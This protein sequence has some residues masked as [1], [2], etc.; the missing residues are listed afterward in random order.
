MRIVISVGVLFLAV[1]FGL[2]YVSADDTEPLTAISLPSDEKYQKVLQHEALRE[3]ILRK[4]LTPEEEK[5]KAEGYE[6]NQ[7]NQFISD[8]LPLSRYFYD[9]RDVSCLK[10][11]YFPV[12]NMPTVSVVIIFHNEARST[13]LRTVQS[14]L[15]RTPRRLLHEIILVDDGS[16]HEFLKA[17]LDADLANFPKTQLIRLTERSGLIR[18]KVHGA[19]AATGDVLMFMDSHCE[20]VD[21]WLEPLLDRIMRDRRTIAMPVIDAIEEGTWEFRTSILQRGVF[22]WSLQFYWLD[23]TEA[24]AALRRSPAEPIVT[25][26]MAGGIFA[27]DRKYFFEIGAYD[28]DMDTWGGE[29]IE[30]SFRVWMCGGRLEILP[31]SRVGH[32]FRAKSPYSFKKDP[33]ETIAHNLNRAARVWMDDRAEIYLNFTNNSRFGESDISERVQLR[34]DLKCH[35]FQWYLDNVFP[36]AFVPVPE[37]SQTLGFLRN[38]TFNMC[39]VQAAHGDDARFANTV[40]AAL[41]RCFEDTDESFDHTWWYLTKTPKAGQLRNED[42]NGA[43]CA[44]P[45]EFALGASISLVH[46]HHHADA[47]DLTWEHTN[48]GELVHVATGLCLTQSGEGDLVV[49]TC[50]AEDQGQVWEFFDEIPDEEEESETGH[51]GEGEASQGG[52]EV[53]ASE[54]EADA[55]PDGESEGEAYPEGESESEDGVVHLDPSSFDIGELPEGAVLESVTV[56]DAQP[57]MQ[58]DIIITREPVVDEPAV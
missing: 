47:D 11:K 34:K 2:F 55:H 30:M 36:D 22:S 5:E 33:T 56:Q 49:D 18:A 37:H 13:L 8:R 42:E 6:R 32:V 16:T 41:Q 28:M 4:K 40:P 7:F 29:N 20:C 46:C 23:I 9:T 25:P 52:E 48:S 57:G 58:D 43:R 14:V 54:G 31:C 24:E 15:D 10:E 53:P 12:R 51:E 1:V 26:A 39:V 19:K 50:D 3:K 35:D 21:G 17:P 45:S 38:P 27:M 44:M